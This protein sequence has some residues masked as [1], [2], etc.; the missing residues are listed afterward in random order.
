MLT[1][2]LVTPTRT[3]TL[4]LLALVLTVSVAQQAQNT[5][6]SET[7]RGVEQLRQGETAQAI[8]T[9]RAAVRHDQNDTA[10]W[11]Y[12]GVALNRAARGATGRAHRNRFGVDR[13][14]NLKTERRTI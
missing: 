1:L 3:A 7:A 6:A 14:P 9:L 8:E 10:G 13:T 2:R 11:Y 4:L 5:L 12:L